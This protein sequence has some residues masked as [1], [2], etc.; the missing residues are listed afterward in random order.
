[1]SYPLVFKK[2][3]S[4]TNKL[5]KSFES[6]TS[7]FDVVMKENTDVFKP[8]FTIQTSERLWDYNYIDG[9]NFSGRQYFITDIRSIGN[10]RF[11]VDAKTDVLS[12]WKSQIRGNSAVIRRQENL[13][14]LYLDDPEFHVLN[15]E[16]IQTLK[17]P[18]NA[19]NKTL[20]YIL[21]VNNDALY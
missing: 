21:V 8:T 2:C 18:A 12:T 20:K 14:N 7:T 4:P 19:F 9:S 1:M 6:G 16:R 11:E 15:Y 10:N 13:F 3:I 17:F 5:D